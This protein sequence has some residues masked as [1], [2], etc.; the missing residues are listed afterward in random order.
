M[1]SA[2]RSG[3]IECVGRLLGE[4]HASARD[5]Y[6]ISCP[7]IEALMEGAVAL[8]ATV[9]AR[10]TGAGW[11]GSIV[12]LVEDDGVREFVAEVTDRYHEQTGLRATAFPCLIGGGA[13]LVAS[14]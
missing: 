14:L 6:E 8:G 12:A 13:A 2:L 4:A 11:G 7:E 9:G 5:D 1:V 10:L 3:D